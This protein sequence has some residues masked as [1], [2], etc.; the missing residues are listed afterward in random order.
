MRQESSAGA[1]IFQIKD[2][3]ILFLL[4]K[5]PTYWGFAKG[6]IESGESEQQAALREIREETSLIVDLI[7]GFSFRQNWMFRHEGELIK[8]QAVFFLAQ[9]P[10]DPQVKISDEHDDFRWVTLQDSL[11]LM[12]VKNNK[13]MI[14]AANEFII[15]NVK[16]DKQTRL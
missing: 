2:E 8:K 13:Q 11:K 4:L 6:W 14:Q 1:V 3:K 10:S 7:P 15:K 12:K 9:V 16:I 5:Y